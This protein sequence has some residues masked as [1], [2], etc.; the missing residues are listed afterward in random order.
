VN[1]PPL[2]GWDVLPRGVQPDESLA[3]E[4]DQPNA[5]R[6]WGA[7]LAWLLRGAWRDE[8]PL[9]DVDGVRVLAAV[10]NRPDVHG[11]GALLERRRPR[12]AAGATVVPAPSV[13]RDHALALLLRR[14]VLADA[15]AALE[16][17]GVPA[18]VLKGLAAAR[19]YPDPALRPAS[20]DID[21]WIAPEQ[22]LS[23]VTAL[24]AAGFQRR[25]SDRHSVY[26]DAGN[27]LTLDVTSQLRV[28]P[29]SLQR[30]WWQRAQRA[31]LGGV[32]ARVLA[33]AD[34]LLYLSLHAARHEFAR[35]K[36]VLDLAVLLEAWDVTASGPV[37]LPRSEPLRSWMLV[38]LGLTLLFLDGSAAA[39]PPMVDQEARHS[40]APWRD[41]VL[42]RWG[43]GRM[44]TPLHAHLRRAWSDWLACPSAAS[45]LSVSRRVRPLVW[46]W[47]TM[48]ALAA[49]V[50]LRRPLRPG[51]KPWLRPL[52]LAARAGNWLRRASPS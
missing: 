27:G 26:L 18:V 39:L 19:R 31:D 24:C 38:A 40:A 43:D 34:E 50:Y 22:W 4:P 47:L 17:A 7:S 11:V 15:T 35:P 6:S 46:Q 45:A 12:S 52:H 1:A 5:C 21:L 32:E 2:A 10:L 48:D 25:E 16:A 9:L 41:A 14:S 51:R 49:H 30:V 13:L 28:V 37:T 23:A 3:P 42:R 20:G 44:H 33:P 8:P 29:A 36:W